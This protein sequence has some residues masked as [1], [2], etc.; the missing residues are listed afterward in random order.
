MEPLGETLAT[1]EGEGDTLML[2]EM[3]FKGEALVESEVVGGMEGV[4]D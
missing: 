1:E 4:G 2:P 3:E